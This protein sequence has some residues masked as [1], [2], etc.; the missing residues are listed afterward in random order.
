VSTRNSLNDP[1]PTYPLA[2]APDG[3]Q[4]AACYAYNQCAHPADFGVVLHDS[5]YLICAGCL[6]ALTREAESATPATASPS[7]RP[8]SFGTLN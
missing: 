2:Q 6:D 7:G 4:A 5:L 8:T 3:P 1:C